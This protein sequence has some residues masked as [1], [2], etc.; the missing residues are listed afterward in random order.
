M[1]S[2]RFSFLLI[3]P[4][5][6]RGGEDA[7]KNWD[8]NQLLNA[9][10]KENFSI[11]SIKI[12]GISN[13][14]I[15]IGKEAPGS[16]GTTQFEYAFDQRQRKWRCASDYP[17]SAPDGSAPQGIDPKKRSLYVERISYEDGYIEATRRV[18]D[19]GKVSIHGWLKVDDEGPGKGLVTEDYDV[20]VPLGYLPEIGAISKVIRS[21]SFQV[22][23]DNI[24]GIPVK[25][26]IGKSP[27]LE[28]SLWL[29]PNCRLALR[30]LVVK[31]P[32]IP[33]NG[34]QFAEYLYK[35]EKLEEKGGHFFP[36]KFH[37]ETMTPGG[38]PSPYLPA[39][40]PGLNPITPEH[41]ESRRTVANVEV[42][43]V[44]VSPHWE[45]KDFSIQ[46]SIPNGTRVLMV[47]AQRLTYVW[48]DGT[49]VPGS[50]A[51]ADRKNGQ[52]H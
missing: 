30:K 21:L 27:K 37:I 29:D 1:R 8:V 5:N 33:I 12:T 9:A 22:H 51:D 17:L 14:Q 50:S 46:M 10:I 6:L 44:E 36:L 28:L 4:A 39:K 31:R 52:N 15:G 11:G 35:V 47:D 2:L 48:V 45:A 23:S 42:K 38:V 20:A 24:D 40:V 3:L 19:G 25:V 13:Q 16:T 26:L 34:V 32:N 18:R 43:K 7:F 41:I 49:V